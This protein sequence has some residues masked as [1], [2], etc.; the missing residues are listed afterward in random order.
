MKLLTS[1]AI[2]PLDS[3]MPTVN[4]TAPTQNPDPYFDQAR[5]SPSQGFQEIREVVHSYERDP[6][7]AEMLAKARKRFAQTC[8]DIGMPLTIASLRL[9]SGLSQTKV[10]ML[11]GNSQSSYSL[12]EVGQREMLYKTFEKLVDIFQVS[13]DE[14]AQAIKNTKTLAQDSS[15]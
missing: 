12:I 4:L 14:L 10:A 8:N 6:S 13:R 15:K 2:N 1:P 11:L 9:R 5:R 3:Q 7:R